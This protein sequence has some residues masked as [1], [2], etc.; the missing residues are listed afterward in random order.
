MI[1]TDCY[2]CG[3]DFAM[4]DGNTL[5][6]LYIFDSYLKWARTFCPVCHKGYRFF[7]AHELDPI[8]EESGVAYEI[9]L[10]PPQ[11]I[12]NLYNERYFPDV[13]EDEVDKFV[14]KLQSI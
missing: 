2:E 11:Y 12:E 7:T 10:T 8:L 14:R 1:I 9:H 3:A 4:H 6:H 13:D 5:R